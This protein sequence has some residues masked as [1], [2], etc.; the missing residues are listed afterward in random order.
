MRALRYAIVAGLAA[1]VVVPAAGA[2]PVPP[3]V[4]IF[5]YPWYGTPAQDGGFEQ[6]QQN[7]HTPPLDLYSAY[8]P[9]SG[10][11][12]SSNT[13]ILDTQMREIR[14][15]GVNE[16]VTSWWGWGSPTDQRLTAV[17]KAAQRVH[18]AVGVHIEPYPGR[19]PDS[20]LGDVTHLALL[21]V[22]DFYVFD[23]ESSP[24]SAWAAVRSSMPAVRLFAQTGHVGF[25]A[26]AGFDGVYTYDIVTYDGD[27]FARYCAQAHRQHLLCAPSV[28]P[29]YD[30]VRADGDKHVKPR[31]RG[32]TY[33]AMWNAAFAATPDVITITS[34]NEWGEGT[35]IEPA[36]PQT[37]YR[38]YDG[39][40][41]LTGRAAE[42]AYLD[43]T[44]LWVERL[45]S[46]R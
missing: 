6:W 38:S 13:R 5:F 11:Y 44:R 24:A 46:V 29:G 43:R 22:T 1:L 21:G 23:A 4:A 42:T 15:A 3:R 8:F 12:S 10:V 16:V 25:A 39:A 41:G 9:A 17:I 33:D 32:A 30:A 26:A 27:K 40:Y 35:Q 37:G 14:R 45:R 20:V 18:L 7:G 36:R 31:K 19:S 2:L 28:G 34:F